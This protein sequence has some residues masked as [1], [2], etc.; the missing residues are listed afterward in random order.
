MISNKLDIL[1]PKF[2][3]D[4]IYYRIT[5]TYFKW[6]GR[7]GAT[8]IAAITMIQLFVLLNLFVF[9]KRLFFD[10]I[11]PVAKTEVIELLLL[12]LLVGLM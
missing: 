11:D 6:D 12:V 9:T 10:T 8:A 2:F 1:K 7:T 4:Y 3:F 5:K